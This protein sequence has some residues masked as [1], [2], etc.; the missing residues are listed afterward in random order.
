MIY[1][2]IEG[3][4]NCVFAGL[5]KFLVIG[6]SVSLAAGLGV[7]SYFSLY[8]KGEILGDSF[9]IMGLQDCFYYLV[10]SSVIVEV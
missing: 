5:S 4:R 2:R 3:I 9:S 10:V 7:A 1:L 6:M 8:Q